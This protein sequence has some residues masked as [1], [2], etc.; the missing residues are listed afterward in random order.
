M[1]LSKLRERC[2]PLTGFCI[3]IKHSMETL[4]FRSRSIVTMQHK[5]HSR[6]W[7]LLCMNV[8]WI[9]QMLKFQ[10]SK[11][12]S[13]N[14]F[15]ATKRLVASCTE[16]LLAREQQNRKSLCS[17]V[18]GKINSNVQLPYAPGIG[19]AFVQANLPPHF[20][21]ARCLSVRCSGRDTS[22]S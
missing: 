3:L 20:G 9:A 17:H 12:C 14:V 5:Y 4:K 7:P 11:L 10:S 16:I 18:S 21:S 19:N 13:C 2:R 1:Q 22:C 15:K 8:Q 6:T